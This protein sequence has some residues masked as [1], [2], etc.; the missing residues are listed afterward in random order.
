MQHFDGD[1]NIGDDNIG[2]QHDNGAPGV[3][4]SRAP[5]MLIVT[6][7]EADENTVETE[8]AVEMAPYCES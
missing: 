5:K 6:T 4:V 3:A 2:V 7:V 1:R 8:I